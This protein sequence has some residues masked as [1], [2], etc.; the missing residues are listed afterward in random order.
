MKK[1]RMFFCEAKVKL[2]IL[3]S[4]RRKEFHVVLWFVFDRAQAGLPLVV[5][6]PLAPDLHFEIL[7][8]VREVEPL[9]LDFSTIDS[10]NS[11]F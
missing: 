10:P 7:T 2:R 4:K 11:I 1:K 8:R 5:F 9:R 6:V 3:E